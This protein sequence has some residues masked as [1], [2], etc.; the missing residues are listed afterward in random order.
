MLVLELGISWVGGP[1]GRHGSGRTSPDGH[2]SPGADLWGRATKGRLSRSP[3]SPADCGP[4]PSSA[5][6]SA[7][8][9][10]SKPGRM[11]LPRALTRSTQ[12]PFSPLWN[13]TRST[14]PARTSVGAL[15][16][17]A[18]SSLHDGDEAGETARDRPTRRR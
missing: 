6:R 5:T 17:G 8:S 14:R 16:F 10:G 11:D 15:I 7:P 2:K 9:A 13:V 12:N 1:E 4:V 3:A 18:W